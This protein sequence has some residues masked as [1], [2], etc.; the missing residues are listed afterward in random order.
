MALALFGAGA[1]TLAGV[2]GTGTSTRWG[3]DLVRRRVAG[4]VASQL[5]PGVQFTIGRL[6]GGVARTWMAESLSL[7]DAQG[8]VV[9]SVTRVSASL[10][11]ASLARGD[12]RLGTVIVEGARANL[13]QSADGSWNVAGLVRKRPP[14]ALIEPRTRR[15]IVADSIALRDGRVDLTMPD[16]SPRLPPVHRVISDLHFAAGR[17]TLVDT[18]GAGRTP[19]AALQATMDDPPVRLISA[20]GTLAW[21]SDSLR[22]DIPR[23]RL[24]RSRAALR[25]TIAWPAGRATDV[26][27]DVD[28][29][30][31]DAADVHWMSALVPSEGAATARVAVRTAG[32]GALRYEVQAFSLR[33]FRSQ[34]SGRFAVTPGRRTEVRD[35]DITLAPLDLELVRDVFGDTILEPAW[36]GAID[37]RVTGRGG[38]LDNLV[39][40]SIAARYTDA[41]PASRGAISR[42]SAHGVVDAAG[43]VTRLVPMEIR[44]D[45]VDVRTLGAIARAADSLHGALTGRVT[46]EGPTANLEFSDLRVRHVDGDRAASV[47]TGF[48]R[49]ASDVRTRWLDAQ[50]T[51]DTVAVGTLVRGR[52]EQP[53]RGI[54]TGTL[55]LHATGDTMQLDARLRAGDATL[56]AMGATLLDSLRTKLDLHG[57]LTRFDP[58]Y[59]VERRDLPAISLGGELRVSVDEDAA[60]VDRHVALVLDTTSRIGDSRILGGTV[61]VGMDAEGLH[62][63]TADVRADRWSVE[64]RGKLAARG[65]SA[66][67]LTFR[68]RVDS[69]GALRTVLLDS[70][71]APRFTALEGRVWTDSGVVRGSFDQLALEANV[72]I[73]DLRVGDAVVGAGVGSVRLRHL[74]DSATGLVRGTIERATAGG[75]TVDMANVEA[76]LTGGTR[77]RI[78]V[79]GASGDTV[80]I[81]AAADVSWP[82]DTYAVRVDSL[83]ARVREHRWRLVVPATA[84]VRNAGI[85]VDS[86]VLRS[87]HGAVA[88]VAGAFPDQG[89]MNGTLTLRRLGFGE[90][91]FLGIVPDGMTGELNASARLTGTRDA[92]TIAARAMLDSVRSDDRDRPGI[93]MDATYAD[94]MAK[95]TLTAALGGRRVFE[96]SGEIPVDLSFRALDERLPDRPVTMRL[97][98]DSVAL[99]DFEGLAPRV[100]ALAGTLRADVEVHGTLREPRGTG[101]LAVAEGAFDMPRYGIS[102]RGMSAVLELSGDSVLV[103]RFRVDDGDSP[104]DSASLTGVIRLAG[105]RWSDWVVA[106]HSVASEFRVIND[107]RVA[108]AEASWNLNVR[109]ALASPRVTGSVHLPYGVFTIGPQRRRTVADT[110]Y[111]A[112]LG[113]PN[114]DGVLV[115][116]GSDVRLKSHDANVQLVGA[117][118]LFGPLDRPW[119]SGSV[120]ATRGTYRVNLGLIKRTFRV[121]SGSVILE[122]TTDTPVAL[123]IFTSYVVRR[124]DDDDVTVRAHLYGTTDRPRLDLT[125]DLGSATA[126]SEIISYLVFGQPSFALQEAAKSRGERTAVAALVPTFGGLLEGVLGTVLPFFSTL[127]VTSVVGNESVRDLVSSPIES[128]LNNYA[129]TG[130]RQVGTDSFLSLSAGLCR[131][132]RVSS[133]S[134]VPSWFG[135]SAEY[136]PKRSVGVL[137]S[138]DPG[139]APC[140]RV[141]SVADTYQLGLDLTYE[142]RFGKKK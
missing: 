108:T 112:R 19:I 45:S 88:V 22:M 55:W 87:D 77:A 11:L 134:N 124:P 7:T 46:L 39:I 57:T 25:G 92:P 131:G 4:A 59:F 94:R 135:A 128:V 130:G 141:S 69:L 116:L 75:Y 91:A 137:L 47:V 15:R 119:V 56:R 85:D 127:Q 21:W 71:G 74:P 136:R 97:R 10:S 132:S 113:I 114:T 65:E 48:G 118:E 102:A 78:V 93:V 109:G 139:P 42:L 37:G 51:L 111:E 105:R 58:G 28:A 99:A 18:D 72:G 30:S 17:T 125:S 34:V 115:T 107:P 9:A 140:S 24:P 110:S 31:V 38:L 29:D 106:M 41:R 40:D 36:Q 86:L 95:V 53:L 123:N 129:I 142:W 27:V 44:L 43:P 52:V 73:A 79:R 14:R 60:T 54:V 120:Q 64:A 76:A 5:A 89:A 3:R 62:V 68:A 32:P 63:D 49:I 121:D 26:R 117:V 103:R 81:G 1:F 12:V 16:T 50:L 101:S 90:L 80:T 70:T 98:T 138:V 2:I 100:T 20:A 61:R 35:L 133:T 84:R 122:G 33:A 13:V 67:V 23:L 104:R 82:D 83:D 66:D 6:D 8:R 126:Q 96:A